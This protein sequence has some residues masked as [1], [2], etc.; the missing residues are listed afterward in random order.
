L[1]GIFNVNILNE[2]LKEKGLQSVGEAQNQTSTTGN[3]SSTAATTNLR[4][5][6]AVLKYY[7]YEQVMLLNRGT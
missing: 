5:D 4:N 1:G 3:G 2:V 6:Q 7:G